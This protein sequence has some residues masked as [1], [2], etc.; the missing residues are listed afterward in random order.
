MS[1]QTN[2]LQDESITLYFTRASFC[3]GD[4]V[5]APNGKKYY[6]KT[7]YSGSRFL[8][9]CLDYLY[10]GMP[11]FHWRG[12]VTGIRIVDVIFKRDG[13]NEVNISIEL[14]DNWRELLER[15][16][17]VHFHH[18][19]P[20]DN[21]LPEMMAKSE[22]WYGYFLLEELKKLDADGYFR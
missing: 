21:T 18:C 20:G 12:Y 16:Q 11:R 4:D 19:M 22:P 2:P 8:E 17:A 3:M 6:W 1:N 7:H 10:L 15:G 5:L 14:V 9:Y 13:E